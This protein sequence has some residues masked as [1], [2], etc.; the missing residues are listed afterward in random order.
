VFPKKKEEKKRL[1]TGEKSF[2]LNVVMLALDTDK[3]YHISLQPDNVSAFC[4]VILLIH[5]EYI[6]CIKQFQ[7]WSLFDCL[8]DR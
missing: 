8:F 5:V 4:S 3:T 1:N 6:S 2:F 7:G